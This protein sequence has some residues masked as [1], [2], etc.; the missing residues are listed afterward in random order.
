MKACVLAYEGITKSKP[1]YLQL[2]KEMERYFKSVLLAPIDNVVIEVDKDVKIKYKG[3]NL[4]S[5][6]AILPRIGP[7]FV[8]FG[9]LILEHLQEEVYF[10]NKI[11]SYRIAPNKFHTLMELSKH[12]LPVPKTLLT[13]SQEMSKTLLKSIGEP[14]I[15][16]RL[17]RS[18]GKGVVYAKDIQSANTF[19][20]ALPHR[21][22]QE[23]LV[24]EY[25]ENPGE[26]IRLFVI[27]DEVAA[28]MKRV[29]K[30]DDIRSNIHAGGK[31]VSYSPT[32]EMVKHAVKAAKVIGADICGVDIINS[33][34]G[35]YIVECNMN[36]GFAISK[37]TGVN[38]FKR[39]AEFTYKNAALFHHVEETSIFEKISDRFSS[40][41]KDIER[42]L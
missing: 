14:I 38:L 1:Y 34:K 26:D 19:L 40:I 41:F 9:T 16:K 2:V 22:G 23:I 35:P 12:N 17:G 6:D 30:R 15:I 31:G 37:V 3:K 20:D 18:G 21:R 27:G 5:F 10:P 11:D 36:P 39:I 8:P 42:R 13:I 7:S 28:C 32:D 33:E 4:G 29:A 25:I 24:E